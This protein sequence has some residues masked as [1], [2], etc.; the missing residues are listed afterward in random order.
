MNDTILLT[1]CIPTNG[2]EKWVIPVLDSIY[3]QTVDAELYE[4]VVTDNGDNESFQRKM[5][6]YK[7]LHKNFIYKKTNAIQFMNQI[8]SFKL[9]HGKLIKFVNHRMIML[10]G[11]LQYLL[12]YVNKYNEKKPIM[13]F[14][15][16]QG[17]PKLSDSYECDCFDLFVKK[18]SYF[19]SWSGGLAIWKD[20]FSKLQGDLLYNELF[21][22]TTIL[23]K[24]RKRD[25]YIIDNMILFKDLV[26][27]QRIKG[28]YNLF[29]AFAVEYMDIIYDLFRMKDISKDTFL[30]IKQENKRFIVN[31][32][33]TFIVLR[34]PC[35]YNLDEYKKYLSVF[36][37]YRE[38][39]LHGIIKIPQ[40][41][42]KKILKNMMS[43]LTGKK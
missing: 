7:N 18:L 5:S 12:M 33:L 30:Y 23:F 3:E 39:L 14:L 13:Y 41:T 29:Q 24:E 17:K 19:S 20:D 32:Y 36:Y 27:D 22:H 38:I 28:K 11:T 35:S 8:E 40:K 42:I 43:A 21:P 6:D 37:S 16:G 15:N 34:T 10:P 31:I 1:L 9:A 25:K 26:T 2:V 4:V